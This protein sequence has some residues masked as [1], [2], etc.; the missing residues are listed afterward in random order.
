ML[1]LAVESSSFPDLHKKLAE[2][3][4]E[5]HILYAEPNKAK[6]FPPL[7]CEELRGITSA[8]YGRKLT[9]AHL[10]Y[11][12]W[13]VI[14][15]EIG[16]PHQSIVACATLCFYSDFPSYFKISFEAVS[17]S[18]QRTGLGRLL[19]ECV[20]AW[21]SVLVVQDPL[22]IEGVMQS[23]GT[24]CIA[25]TIDRDDEYDEDNN[26]GSPDDNSQGHGAFLK[27]LCFVRATHDFRPDPETEIGFQLEFHLPIHDRLEEEH[28]LPAR[29]SSA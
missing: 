26:Y 24:Y 28:A 4:L 19:F 1:R 2:R 23:K 20:T 17:P 9:P 3:D 25:A 6:E 27:K 16:E 22:V 12:T 10:Q 21:T 13:A 29:P 14:L 8:A 7:L 11:E 18:H 5:C 15:R